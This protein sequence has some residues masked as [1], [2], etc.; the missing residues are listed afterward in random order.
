MSP[1]PL[2]V[3]LLIRIQNQMSWTCVIPVFCYS[4]EMTQIFEHYQG[5][6]WRTLSR[7][8]PH[9]RLY[10][11]FIYPSADQSG[12]G[13]IKIDISRYDMGQIR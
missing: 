12:R 6:T 9:K 2:I 1:D 3:M 10:T 11:M 5:F 7:R 13:N 8:Y 4:T